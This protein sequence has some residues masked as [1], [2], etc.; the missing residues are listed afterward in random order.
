M[1]FPDNIAHALLLFILLKGGRGLINWDEGGRDQYFSENETLMAGFHR[2]NLVN[3]IRYGKPTF[4]VPQISFVGGKTWH[5]NDGMYAKK[6]RHP[7]VR[8]VKTRGSY[9]VVGHNPILNAQP[10]DVTLNSRW[11]SGY[12]SVT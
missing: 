4:L 8:V 1:Y 5:E 9:V 10:L 6:N 2:A 3:D 12:D 7:I 11:I